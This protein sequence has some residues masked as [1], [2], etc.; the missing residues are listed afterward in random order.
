MHAQSVELQPR[1]L[2]VDDHADTVESTALLLE[3]LGVSVDCAYGGAMAI[4]I[5]RASNPHLVLLDLVMPLVDGYDVADALRQLP[6]QPT[7]VAVSGR[8]Q[9]ADKVRCAEAGFD[10]H[11]TKPV[12]FDVLKQLVQTHSNFRA[13]KHRF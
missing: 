9:P 10:L 2:V 5:G 7:L 13:L 1:V 12:P 11:L 4:E 8:N 6:S 3:A